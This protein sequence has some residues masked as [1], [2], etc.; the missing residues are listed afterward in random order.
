MQYMIHIMAQLRLQ[1]VPWLPLWYIKLEISSM[2][3]LHWTEYDEV[4]F[5]MNFCG[6]V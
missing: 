6:Q 4:P 2:M 5:M 1:V 3:P